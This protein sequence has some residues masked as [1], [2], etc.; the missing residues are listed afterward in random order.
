MR[1]VLT[2]SIT[3]VLRIEDSGSKRTIKHM[4]K[5]PRR[6]VGPRRIIIKNLKAPEREVVPT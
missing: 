2:S 3:S 1:E 5:Y 4:W 6:E